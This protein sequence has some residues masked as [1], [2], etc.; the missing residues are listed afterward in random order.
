LCVCVD[1]IWWWIKMY[2]YNT[3]HSRGMGYIVVDRCRYF[4]SVSFFSVYRSVFFQ[5]G[6]VFV[7]L[8]VV[9]KVLRKVWPFRHIYTGVW[10]TYGQTDRHVATAKTA[11][12][13][14][15][16]RVKITFCTMH[17]FLS[18]QIRLRKNGMACDIRSQIFLHRYYYAPPLIGGGIKWCFCLASVCLSVA[19]IRPKSR[20]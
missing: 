2:I 9:E 7:L 11:L 4:K 18:T 6:S 12:T 10:R 16:A 20:T 15:V 17:T 5:I 3:H 19:Y 8:Q 13:C 1:T 14:C